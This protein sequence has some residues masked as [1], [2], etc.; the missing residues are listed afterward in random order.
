MAEHIDREKVLHAM[1]ID[2][3]PPFA[4]VRDYLRILCAL[5]ADHRTL[6]RNLYDPKPIQG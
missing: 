1:K 3:Q 4:V 6:L 5:P 2:V